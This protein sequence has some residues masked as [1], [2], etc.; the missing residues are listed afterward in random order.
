MEMRKRFTLIE[1]L[2]VIAII[3][4]LASMLLPALNRA[5]ATAK[6]AK[7]KSTMKQLGLAHNMYAQDHDDF[8]VPSRNAQSK[9]WFL[10]LGSYSSGFFL[11]RYNTGDYKPGTDNTEA[12]RY[13]APVCSEYPDGGWSG[14]SNT[15]AQRKTLAGYGGIAANRY[16]GFWASAK[17]DKYAPSK[18]AS[19]K[20]PSEFMV[21]GE[22]HYGAVAR[23]NSSWLGA[24]Q[25]ARFAHPD[26]MS[27]L[28]GDGHVGVLRGTAPTAGNMTQIN[29]YPDGSDVK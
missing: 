14:D 8:L 7:C 6:G 2:V 15:E 11:Q 1:L 22:A 29:W 4:I 5:R 16:L 12:D 13:T 18:I 21:N 25:S 9:D 17:W 24:W 28:H 26:G 20:R 23:D 3:A 27:L 19:I 10:F